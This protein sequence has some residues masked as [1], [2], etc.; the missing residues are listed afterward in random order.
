MLL[1]LLPFLIRAEF[2]TCGKNSKLTCEK[3]NS[4][5]NIEGTGDELD[6]LPPEFQPCTSINITNTGDE[7]I[8]LSLDQSTHFSSFFFSS[9]GQGKI[10]FIPNSEILSKRVSIY[11]YDDSM[12]FGSFSIDRTITWNLHLYPINAIPQTTLYPDIFDYVYFYDGLNELNPGAFRNHAVLNTVDFSNSN[13]TSLPEYA[14]ANCISLSTV[15]RNRINA[16]GPH[17]FENCSSLTRLRSSTVLITQVSEYAFYNCTKFNTLGIEQENDP[18][19]VEIHY[20]KYAFAFTLFSP[21]FN[22]YDYIIGENCFLGVQIRTQ[23]F[24]STIQVYNNDLGC[25]FEDYYSTTIQIVSDITQPFGLKLPVY[26][27][28]LK[29]NGDYVL[30]DDAFSQFTDMSDCTITVVEKISSLP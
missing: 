5:L 8:T 24:R 12:R 21:D 4:C 2:T 11:V 17:C 23:T 15:Y 30:C 18:D 20:E 7:N 27:L 1:V 16:F 13:I 28:T 29:I 10:Q 22:Y 9:Q 14:F 26:Q 6:Q 19:P 25:T 3:Q